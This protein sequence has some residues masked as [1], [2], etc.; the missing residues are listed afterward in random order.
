[1]KKRI[2]IDVSV[3]AIIAILAISIWRN[4]GLLFIALIHDMDTPSKNDIVEYVKDSSD[5]LLKVISEIDALEQEYGT[6]GFGPHVSDVGHTDIS[7]YDDEVKGLYIRIDDPNLGGSYKEINNEFLER[8]LL[9]EPIHEISVHQEGI[10]FYCGGKG[11]GSATSY[12]GFYY[13]SDGMP[14]NYWCGASFGSLEQ[15]KPD[16]EGFSIKFSNDDNC[17]YTEKIID[18]FFYY[19]AHF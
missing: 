7:A 4:F 15:L 14:K 3:I 17:Y 13:T 9:G 11:L 1:M 19:E 2:I 12:Y 18:N 10:S 6:Q 5:D 16:G 8:I